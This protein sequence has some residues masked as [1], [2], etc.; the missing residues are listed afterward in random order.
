MQI[1]LHLLLLLLLLLHPLDRGTH[2]SQISSF[3]SISPP[4]DVLLGKGPII[5]IQEN[6]AY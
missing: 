6:K 4:K 5:V 1:I 3:K 2:F